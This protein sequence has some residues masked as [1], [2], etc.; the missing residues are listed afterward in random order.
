M[1]L[2]IYIC[3][4]DLFTDTLVFNFYILYIDSLQISPKFILPL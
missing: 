1:Y 3:I 4:Y 2:Y